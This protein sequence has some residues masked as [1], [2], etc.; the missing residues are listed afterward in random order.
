MRTLAALFLAATACNPPVTGDWDGTLD[1]TVGDITFRASSGAAVTTI[2]GFALYLSDQ[3]DACEAVSFV[4]A[5]VATTL[6]LRV[7]PQSGG[8]VQAT[9]VGPKPVPAPGEATGG[10]VRAAAGVPLVAYDAADG[11]VSWTANL[12]G[13]VRLDAIDVGFAGVAGRVTAAD[14]RLAAC[15]P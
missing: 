10:L 6:V 1:F 5:G 13:S 14:L 9:V 12:D 15:S 11:T 2:Y 7:A 3:P 4:P 8:V